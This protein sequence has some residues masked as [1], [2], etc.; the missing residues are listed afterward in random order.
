LDFDKIDANKAIAISSM[1]AKNQLAQMHG[2]SCSIAKYN[3]LTDE[4]ANEIIN[5]AEYILYTN[6]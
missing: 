5:G 3:P 2:I 6:S 1:T 4:K